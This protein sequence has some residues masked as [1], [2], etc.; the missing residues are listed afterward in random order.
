[1]FNMKKALAVAMTV[2]LMTPATA[3][4]AGSPV[5]TSIA[6]QTASV[7][8]QYSG[9]DEVLKLTINGKELVEGEDFEIVGE[10]PTALG[11]YQ[12]KIKG[13]KYYTGEATVTYTIEKADKPVY[14]VSKKAQKKLAKGFKAS[15][16]KKKS[17]K[18]KLNVKSDGKITGFKVKG[19]KAKKW[20]TVTK[21]GVVTL[22]KGIKKGTYK[23]RIQ[24]KGTE[25]FKKGFQT[26]KIVVK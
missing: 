8:K 24:I 18:I 14:K 13:I 17:Q 4:A 19:K 7:T 12:L 25:N 9:K 6:G 2:A 26:I 11:T 5:L 23:I 16:L 15:K 20:I 1:M 22:K 3:F 21:K 10:E